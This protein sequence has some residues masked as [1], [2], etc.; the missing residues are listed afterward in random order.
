VLIPR[1]KREP[2][3]ENDDAR[4]KG[5]GIVKNWMSMCEKGGKKEKTIARGA[6]KM[7]G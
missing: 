2:T 7:N 3:D 1:L 4:E 5:A 6:W